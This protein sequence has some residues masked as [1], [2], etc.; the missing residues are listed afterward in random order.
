MMVHRSLFFSQLTMGSELA[1]TPW[2]HTS[3]FEALYVP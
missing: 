2:L 3:Q 1:Q